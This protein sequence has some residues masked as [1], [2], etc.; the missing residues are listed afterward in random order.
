MNIK[1]RL[2]DTKLFSSKPIIYPSRPLSFYFNIILCLSL[3]I[4]ACLLYYKYINK[5]DNE[6]TLRNKLLYLNER[7]NAQLKNIE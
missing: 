1:P 2:V 6:I 3:I 7:I 5:N 4:G